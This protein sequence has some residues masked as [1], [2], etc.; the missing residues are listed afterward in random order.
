LQSA[1]PP[2]ENAPMASPIPVIDLF[3]GPGGL[4]EGF[5][6]Y[7]RD[8]GPAFDIRLSIEKDAQAHATLELRSFFRQF[9][10]HR[11]PEQYY[12]FLRDAD[13]PPAVRRKR[14]FDA[15]PEQADAAVAEAWQAELGQEDSRPR[16]RT[17]STSPA[18]RVQYVKMWVH[19][20]EL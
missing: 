17:Q 10:R 3:A 11:I 16:P 6:A 2:R 9:P 7:A 15:F 4:G 18:S 13:V 8:G 19:A 1:N 14:L 5:S 20:S 12:D